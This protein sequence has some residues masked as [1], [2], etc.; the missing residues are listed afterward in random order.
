[1][2]VIRWSFISIAI[3]VV[4]LVI[5]GIIFPEL[6]KNYLYL[7]IILI[8]LAIFAI[9]AP[10]SLHIKQFKSGAFGILLITIVF[11]IIY[12]FI[13]NYSSIIFYTLTALCVTF[14]YSFF[15]TILPSQASKYR[16]N[17]EQS[18]IKGYHIHE[19]TF[20]ILLAYINLFCNRCF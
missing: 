7:C 19:N 13:W 3:S 6:W 2:S 18:S 8:P 20:G 12:I 5:L 4:V 9:I 11:E 14:S 16:E 1:M 17:Y 10:F 15:L